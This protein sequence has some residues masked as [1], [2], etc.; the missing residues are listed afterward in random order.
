MMEDSKIESI[1][2]GK[3]RSLSDECILNKESTLGV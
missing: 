3:C 2:I 1:N